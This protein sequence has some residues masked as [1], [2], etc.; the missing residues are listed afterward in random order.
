MLLDVEPID[1]LCCP[2]EEFLSQI[3]DPRCAIAEYHP[4]SS[5]LEAPPL[6]FSPNPLRKLGPLRVGIRRRRT[7]NGR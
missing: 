4:V 5:L 2:R 6:G 1:D 7:F 3:P